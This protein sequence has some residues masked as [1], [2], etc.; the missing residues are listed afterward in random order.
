[1]TELD[2]FEAYAEIYP[3][4]CLLLVD[5]IDTLSSGVPNAIRVFEKL[6]RK[7]YTPVG[8]RLD[9]GDL[10]FLST[11]VAQML[12]D[13]GFP[14]ASIVLSNELDELIIR[15]IKSQIAQEAAHSGLD[16]DSII[17][18][19][20]YGVGTRLITSAGDS[21]LGGV[22]KLVGLQGDKGWQ[23]AIK[24]SDDRGKT[25]IPGSKRAWRIYDTRGRATSDLMTLEDEDP[26]QTWQSARRPSSLTN[27]HEQPALTLRH[28][29]ERAI[30]RTLPAESISHIEPLLL[31]VM[32]D[33]RL[34]CD[35]P[36]IEQSR[37]SRRA[38][39][40][41]LDNGVR[42]LINP[43]PYHVSVSE[44][45]WALQE[46]LLSSLSSRRTDPSF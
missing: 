12:D 33:G 42:R 36:S 1:M 44:R 14:D 20:V 10:A 30:R 7:G 24:V 23:P 18:R 27:D 9:S 37:A 2:A 8:V 6:R 35:R 26:E 38:D 11:H 40:A 15:E 22:Y 31:N 4:E 21:S 43:Q 25:A 34:V 16:A 3:D 32:T 5:T 17:R 19:L 28:P 39:V 46:K 45:L 41:R 13:A 29:R